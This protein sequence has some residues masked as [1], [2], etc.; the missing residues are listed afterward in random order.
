MASSVCVHAW[1]YH[2]P[3]PRYTDLTATLCS[4]LSNIAMATQRAAQFNNAGVVLVGW[5]Q[6]LEALN[7]FRQALECIMGLLGTSRLPEKTLSSPASSVQSEVDFSRGSFSIPFPFNARKHTSNKRKNRCT[8]AELSDDTCSLL[9]TTPFS[10]DPRVGAYSEDSLLNTSV[11]SAIILFNLGVLY[12]LKSMEGHG[13]ERKLIKARDLYE[14]SRILLTDAGVSIAPTGNPVVDVLYLA[15]MNNLA[16]VSYDLS[17]Y[18]A[19]RCYAYL[20]IEFALSIGPVL[21]SSM[22]TAYTMESEKNR[23]LLMASLRHIP[24]LA[25]AA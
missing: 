15:V 8:T 16:Q 4:S 18:D 17:S 11:V 13:S 2:T 10:M 21:Y 12:H 6:L 3:D 24:E 23:F 25:P 22:Q 1:L 7:T 19:A 5:G 14:K 9:H 20:L